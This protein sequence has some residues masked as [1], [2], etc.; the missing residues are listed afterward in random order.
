MRWLL[1]TLAV[2]A[3]VPQKAQA[4][5]HKVQSPNFIVYSEGKSDATIA[6]AK[7]LER[8]D[9][10][11]RARLKAREN[12]SGFKLTVFLVGSEQ[13]GPLSR[14][15][16]ASIKGFHE[17][18]PNGPMAVVARAHS[19]GK[20]DLDADTILFHEYAHHFMYQ[21]T[22][23][24]YPVWFVEG[25]AEFYS[26]TEFDEAGH[27]SYGRPAYHRAYELVLGNTIPIEKFLTGTS[28]NKK[29]DSFYGRA[30]A[31]THY[32]TFETAREGQLNKYLLAINRGEDNLA[33]ARAAFG[34]LKTLNAEIN[35]YLKRSKISFLRTVDP[36]EFNGSV[37]LDPID[38]GE[39]NT[40]IERI[41]IMRGLAE[42][43]RP[44]VLTSLDK[45]RARFPTSATIA[46]L[47]AQLLYESENYPAA[48]STADDALALDPS[49]PRALLYKGLAESRELI[50]TSISD[51]SRWKKARGYIVK[52]NRIY[53][54][55]P[56]PLYRYYLS[57]SDEG[58]SPPE[59][60]EKGLARAYDLVPQD[61]EIRFTYAR[62]LIEKKDLKS[63]AALI[64]P[65]A[66]DPHG[67]W[68]DY[69]QRLVAAL[70]QAIAEDKPFAWPD[71]ESPPEKPEAGG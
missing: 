8:F 68:G 28:D 6:F 34:D 2:V 70:D 67:G 14:Q 49:E 27:A 48:G 44:G 62:L 55:N 46:G 12:G 38:P 56:Y 13:A 15:R 69:G 21:H 59:L 39:A 61:P 43:E 64:R 50:K 17:V 58:K 71:G 41:K 60:A 65:L 19:E 47:R 53:P 54:D 20:Y 35:A 3:A 11:L 63:A 57:F 42:N 37:K 1:A 45:A 32:L 40:I 24:A 52:A 18:G 25:F 26:S 10:F 9:A 7:K 66:F 16:S 30:W 22:P 5:W 23:A 31:T 29:F 33:A 51:A 36:I 4:A